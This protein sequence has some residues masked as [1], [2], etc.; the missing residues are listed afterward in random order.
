[1]VPVTINEEVTYFPTDEE[2][3]R[4]T[5]KIPGPTRARVTRIYSDWAVDLKLQAEGSLPD[6]APRTWRVECV[7]EGSSAGEFYRESAE[8]FSQRTT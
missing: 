1:M 4:V 2:R 7:H 8:E 5:L 3:S 6:L